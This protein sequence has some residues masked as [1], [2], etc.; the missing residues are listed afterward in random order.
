M[1]SG[2][3]ISFLS[4]RDTHQRMNLFVYDLGEHSTKQLT[5]FTEFDIK[6]PS[7][8]DQ[9]IVFENG[10]YFYRFDPASADSRQ[11]PTPTLAAHPARPAAI[12][13]LHPTRTHFQ[14]S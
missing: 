1:W 10:G 14:I 11:A 13:N 4:D 3:K 2:Q 7:L 12:I 6:F 9:A 5:Q 8:G